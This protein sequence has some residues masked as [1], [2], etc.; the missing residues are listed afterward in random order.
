MSTITYGGVVP[1]K[2]VNLT[3]IGN[4]LLSVGDWVEVMGAYE[5]DIPTARGSLSIAGFVLVANTVA[6]G[7]VTVSSRFKAVDTFTAGGVIAAGDPVVVDLDG[8][9]VAY[10]PLS[11]PGSEDSCCAIVGI[12]L[13]AAIAGGLLDV[14]VL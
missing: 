7:D 6:G 3:C 13:T 4:T 10:D 11:S 5:V 12:A 14:G 9:L 2:G 1:N 8:D